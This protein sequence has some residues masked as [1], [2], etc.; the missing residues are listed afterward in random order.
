MRF[1]ILMAE[2]FMLAQIS[3]SKSEEHDRIK[4]E[5]LSSYILS[6]VAKQMEQEYNEMNSLISGLRESTRAEIAAS[7]VEKRVRFIWIYL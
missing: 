2:K 5:F 1:S 3:L 6:T 4:S 7:K